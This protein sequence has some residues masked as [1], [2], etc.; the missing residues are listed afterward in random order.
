MTTS[1]HR[2]RA[3]RLA[4][5]G[6]LALLALWLTIG[7][8]LASIVDAR[9]PDLALKA[10]PLSATARAVQ[11]A[12]LIAPGMSPRDATAARTLARDALALDPTSVVAAR[13]LGVLAEADGDRAKAG[14]LRNYALYLSR[15]DLPTQLWTIETAVARNDIATALTH[16]DQALLT[17]NSAEQLLLPILVAATGQDQIREPL[18]AK[19]RT[20]P[21]WWPSFTRELFTTGTDRR[22]IVSVFRLFG[23]ARPGNDAQRREFASLGLSR[24]IA[25]GDYA[26]AWALVGRGPR[27]TLV[28]GDFEQMSA[29]PPFGWQLVDEIDLSGVIQPGGDGASGYA[30][31]PSASGGRSGDAATQ[32][33][34]LRPGRYTLSARTSGGFPT[35]SALIVRCHGE[36]GTPLG[37]V[38]L[39]AQSAKSGVSLTFTVPANG[40]GGQMVAVHAASGDG[41]EPQGEPAWIDAVTLKPGV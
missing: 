15:R 28:N 39:P 3:T 4:L 1:A 18:L 40:C 35:G 19:L 26:D 27:D 38:D 30:L 10:Y 14:R 33:V 6:V 24:L 8:T 29:P 12:S 13:S 5:T 31:F 7:A 37:S 32:F 16:Y 34:V 2:P 11:A 20:R 22:M 9:S 17:S 41:G 36:A 25:L 21:I 23:L